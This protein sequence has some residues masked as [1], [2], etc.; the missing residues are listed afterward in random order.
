LSDF[1]H[2]GTPT[3]A[4]GPVDFGVLTT[5]EEG[6]AIKDQP[7]WL[8]IKLWKHMKATSEQIALQMVSS[9]K[10]KMQEK[11]FGGND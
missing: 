5:S 4:Y 9:L 8:R 11:A 1:T 6:R 3:A 2:H 10:K 7:K